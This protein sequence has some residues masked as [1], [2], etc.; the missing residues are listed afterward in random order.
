M[1]PVGEELIPGPGRPVSV[2]GSID[3]GQREDME[4]VETL[5]GETFDTQFGRTVGGDGSC[6]R[7]DRLSIG[8]DALVA[9]FTGA[10]FCQ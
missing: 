7:P 4:L 3:L 6:G 9:R 2:V 10:A 8:S 1:S 5:A